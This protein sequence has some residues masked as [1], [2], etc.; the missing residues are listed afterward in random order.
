MKDDNEQIKHENIDAGCYIPPHNRRY[1]LAKL[2]SYS[3]AVRCPCHTIAREKR[4]IAT[5]AQRGAQLQLTVG[6][7]SPRCLGTT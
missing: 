6:S 5:N 2:L 1:R 3:A 7:L 4:Q